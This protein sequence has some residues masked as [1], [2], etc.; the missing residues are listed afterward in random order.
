MCKFLKY[1][2]FQVLL[3]C[4][5]MSLLAQ[6]TYLKRI[7][8][9]SAPAI[10]LHP[11][12]SIL[13]LLH[14]SKSPDGNSFIHIKTER[15]ASQIFKLD[16]QGNILWTSGGTYLGPSTR[17]KLSSVQATSDGGVMF[18]EVYESY[19][20]SY[21]KISSIYKIDNW[22][23]LEWYHN[24][25][26]QEPLPGIF[27]QEGY[28]IAL[29]PSGY[30][31]LAD[32][33]IYLYHINGAP[34]GNLNF[35]GP[36][37]I[38]GFDNGDIFL[39]LDTNSFRARIDSTGNVRYTLSSEIYNYDTTLYTIVG[40]TIHEIDGMT[41]NYI[42]SVYAQNASTSQIQMLSDGGW[43]SGN[44]NRYSH[45]GTLRWSKTISLPH[46]GYDVVGEQSDGTLMTGGTYLSVKDD[47]S[48]IDYSAFITTIDSL[49]KSV[50]DSTSQVWMLD[51][52]DDGFMEFSDV[53]YVALAR[54]STGPLRHDSLLNNG[55]GTRGDIAIDFPGSF[56]TGVNHK[57]CDFFPDGLIDSLD[58]FY[59][60]LNSY[61][62]RGPTPWRLVNPSN[63]NYS[64]H[65]LIPYFSC[66][67]DRDSAMTGDTVRFNFILGD[68]GV[69]VD[70]IFGLAFWLAADSTFLS[71]SEM[72]I[73]REVVESDFGTT[74]D[75]V[76]ILSAVS[77]HDIAMMTSRRDQQNSYF[78]QDTIGFADIIITD[79]SGGN[80][81]LNFI[82]LSFKAITAGGFPV[83]FQFNTKPLH[84]SSVINK[85][86]EYNFSKTTIYPVPAREELVIDQIP[87]NAV[88]VQLFNYEGK[89]VYS[90]FSNYKTQVRLSL[91]GYAP[92]IYVLLMRNNE[93]QTS[94]RK[95]IKE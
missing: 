45:N 52:N 94:S 50:V 14:F 85:V 23:T 64:P 39:D 20:S 55:F 74:S 92:G 42:S 3:F 91:E 46:F 54:G 62:R 8:F 90:G 4:C 82:L 48:N 28:D 89:E 83:D 12:D 26:S 87:F 44:L 43:L 21:Q 5:S 2:I 56:A 32:D 86:P 93:N 19:L 72:V 76:K 27:V 29:L 70:S 13:Q 53:V 80:V 34:K 73:K 51:A 35:H 7:S 57:Q 59:Y 58:L 81:D 38:I 95:F 9:N 79:S 88:T 69:L 11:E 47:Y 1:L 75:Q 22:G 30:A 37:K 6:P 68:N 10:Y 41:G 16:L 65:S 77:P 63:N 61:V 18:L 25:P 15:G 49:G 17:S 24:L 31:C 67:P 78:F 36:G 66:L 40:D 33:S 84:I 60:S 71:S